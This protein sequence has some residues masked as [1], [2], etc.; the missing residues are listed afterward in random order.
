[1]RRIRRSR[2]WGTSLA[3][4]V[5]LAGPAYAEIWELETSASAPASGILF[6][7]AAALRLAEEVRDGRTAAAKVEAYQVQVQALQQQIQ[8]LQREVQERTVE[9]NARTVAQ[10]IAEE[11]EKLREKDDARV[12]KAL[13]RAEKALQQYEKLTDKLTARVESL[14]QRQFWMQLLGP[15]GLAVGFFLGH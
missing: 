4:A 2:L 3:L 12:D 10:A 5:A 6:D 7:E 11:R 15:L 14:E 9:G 8:S 13:A 1:M